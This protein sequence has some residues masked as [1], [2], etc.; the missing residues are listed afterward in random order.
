MV[1]KQPNCSNMIIF[2]E[3]DNVFRTKREIRWRIVQ[4]KRS[5]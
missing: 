4:L 3:K 5:R 2:L 1:D